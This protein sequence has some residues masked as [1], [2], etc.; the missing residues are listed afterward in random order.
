MLPVKARFV[1]D[2]NAAAVSV[3]SDETNTVVKEI[4]LGVYGGDPRP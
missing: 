3:I 4:S 2:Y 1:A